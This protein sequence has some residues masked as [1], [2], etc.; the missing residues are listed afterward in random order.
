M[1]FKRFFAIFALQRNKIEFQIYCEMLKSDYVINRETAEKLAKEGIIP[2]ETLFRWAK[3]TFKG[4]VLSDESAWFLTI[5]DVALVPYMTVEY[6]PTLTLQEVLEILPKE[7][8]IGETRNFLGINMVDQYISYWHEDA[9]GMQHNELLCPFTDTAMAE[10]AGNLLLEL[11][12][13]IITAGDVTAVGTEFVIK[14]EDSKMGRTVQELI[15]AL[16]KVEN[17]DKEV[18]V[19]GWCRDEET[20]EIQYDEATEILKMEDKDDEFVITI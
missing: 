14:D 13:R 20:Y 1:V 4:K 7:I 10:A 11:R 2:T 12:K 18:V 16:S 3:T 19:N 9:Y 5:D 15:D 17:K 8:T 6:I